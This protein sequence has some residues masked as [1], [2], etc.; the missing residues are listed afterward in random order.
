MF[1][2]PTS[3]D[4]CLRSRLFDTRI[5]GAHLADALEHKPNGYSDGVSAFKEG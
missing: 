2:S 4:G 3:M 5:A 1:Y